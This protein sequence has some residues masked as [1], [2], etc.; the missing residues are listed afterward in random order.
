LGLWHGCWAWL[1]TRP[2]CVNRRRA[3]DWR[4]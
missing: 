2:G 4:V 1:R 3:C